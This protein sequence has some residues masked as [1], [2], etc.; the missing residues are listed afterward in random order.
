MHSEDMQEARRAREA[1][2]KSV[3]DA[4]RALEK[5]IHELHAA[6]HEV[7]RLRASRTEDV[8]RERRAASNPPLVERRRSLRDRRSAHPD[9]AR[10][11]SPP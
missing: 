11:A 4:R 2:R 6:Q 1:A 9:R 8:G 10:D 5:A 7:L 3:D